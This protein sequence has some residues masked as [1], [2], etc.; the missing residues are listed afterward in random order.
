[1]KIMKKALKKPENKEAEVIKLL[2]LYK[3][4]GLNLQNTARITAHIDSLKI[5]QKNIRQK[6]SFPHLIQELLLIILHSKFL[7]SYTNHELK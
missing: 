5:I 1:M 3:Y 2:N 6:I 7:V 4:L